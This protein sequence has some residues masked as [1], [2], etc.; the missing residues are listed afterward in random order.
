[1]IFSGIYAQGNIDANEDSTNMLS[2]IVVYGYLSEQKIKEVPASVSVLTLKQIELQSGVSPVSAMNTLAGVRMEERSPGSYRLSLRGSTLRSPY[3]IRNVKVYL[4]EIPLTDA[5][6]NTYLNAL[7]ISCIRNIEVMKGP[8]GSLWG[9]NSGGIVLLNPMSRNLTDNSAEIKFD[10]GSYGLI[11]QS[12]KAHLNIGKNELDIS[13]AYQSYKGYREHSSMGRMYFQVADRFHYGQNNKLKF[14]GFYSNLHYETPGGLTLEQF[15]GNPKS[16]RPATATLPGAIEQQIG[17]R[18]KILW[19][20]LINEAH[21]SKSIKNVTAIFGSHV[22]FENPFITNFEKRN[23]LTYGARSYFEYTRPVKESF[24]WTAILG[25]E[26]QQTQA[27]IDNYDNLNGKTGDPQAWDELSTNQYFIFS[28][29]AMTL[30]EKLN[31]E[32]G[33][34]LN[35]Y[36]YK[37]RNLY[38]LN[39]QNRSTRNFTPQLMP[40]L[41]ASYSLKENLI[42]RITLSRG[43]AT[44]TIAEVR[45]SSNVVNTGLNP[46]AGWNIETGFRWSDKNNRVRMDA[47]VYYYRLSNAIVSRRFV[48]DTDYFLNGGGTNQLG[49][50]L[51]FKAT[52]VK[53]RTAGFIREMHLSEVLSI[54]HFK[55]RNYMVNG[56][57][58]SGNNLT[59]TPLHTSVIGLHVI[60]PAQLYLYVQCNFTGRIPLNDGN[61]VYASSYELLQA[62]IG[63]Q[64]SIAK[65]SI[66]IYTGADNIL[67]QKYSLGNDLN[68][69]G[70]RFYN[71]APARNI[72]AG[73]Q[74]RI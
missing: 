23:E 18:T 55:F 69:F 51:D 17:V 43:Y 58:Y 8:D 35:N 4:D 59:G 72:Y 2:A 42:W 28:R 30:F 57:D 45:P 41:A 31:I 29:Y 62:K 61:T 54:S 38:P 12:A 21:L 11:H 36:K 34:S 33:I 26:W 7:D 15:I 25:A 50:E 14:L 67:N 6:G 40:R 70:N 63:W 5:G 68:A 73:L 47:S 24:K 46:E 20:G 60:F 9:A 27:K 56:N 49:L 66:H 65:S 13:Q 19:G 64:L 53:K 74:L 32:A 71:P 52:I 44:P 22:D 10:A 1:M 48:D 39:E 16:S 37:F 3:G